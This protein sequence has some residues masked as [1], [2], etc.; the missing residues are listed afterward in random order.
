M[1]EYAGGPG[2]GDGEGP[3]RRG[4]GLGAAAAMAMAAAFL[5]ARGSN[6]EKAAPA[7]SR[8]REAFSSC[9]CGRFFLGFALHG[10]RLQAMQES[11]GALGISGSGEDCALVV[12]KYAQPVLDI[13]G[14][15]GAR[16][17]RQA[18]VGAKKGASEFGNQF[19]GS[20]SM[21]AEAVGQ[22]AVKAGSV[23]APMDCLMT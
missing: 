4:N 10:L 13:A 6:V 21:T 14:M 12:F 7:R 17:R 1:P 11:G 8:N 23:A 15:I 2:A 5:I 9:C 22:V 19:L 18:K 16:L 3:K 20:V